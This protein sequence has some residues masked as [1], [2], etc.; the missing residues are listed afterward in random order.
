ML[1]ITDLITD[2][3]SKEALKQA[4]YDAAFTVVQCVDTE[5]FDVDIKNAIGLIKE[6][7]DRIK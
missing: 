6:I 1:E 4:L 3:G 7:A 2:Y 5:M